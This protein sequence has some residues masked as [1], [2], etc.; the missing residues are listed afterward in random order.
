MITHGNSIK[1]FAG[2]ACKN[3]AKDIANILKMELGDI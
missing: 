2:N 3:L 1:V